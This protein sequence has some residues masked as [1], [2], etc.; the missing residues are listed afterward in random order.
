NLGWAINPVYSYV[1]PSQYGRIFKTTDGG[2]T[3]QLLKDSSATFYRSIGFA[4]SLT[5]WVGN[6]GY[7]SAVSRDTN[8]LYQTSDG[9]ITWMPAKIP[10]PHPVGICGI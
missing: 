9:G 5:G 10:Y 4:D 7:F 1:Y 2:N 8:V 6:L 3:W